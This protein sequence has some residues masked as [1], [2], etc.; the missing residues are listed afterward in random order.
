MLL[1]GAHKENFIR[2]GAP[3]TGAEVA[4]LAATKKAPRQAGTKVLAEIKLCKARRKAIEALT[5]YLVYAEV[6]RST[7]TKKAP[8]QAEGRLRNFST[9]VLAAIKFHQARRTA[10][11]GRRR[12]TNTP[13]SRSRSND[14]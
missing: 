13:R 2:R 9:K 11:R 6:V 5:A 1:L 4:R 3:Q 14:A 10:D 8:R 7:A 12:I